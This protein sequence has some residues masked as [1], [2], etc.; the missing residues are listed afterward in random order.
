M[1][2]ESKEPNKK[3][4]SRSPVQV[5]RRV[6]AHFDH[7]SFRK[8]GDGCTGTEAVIDRLGETGYD[9]QC[10]DRESGDEVVPF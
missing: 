10:V 4:L 5:V 3:V 8:T 1:H 9:G 7:P 2:P 6:H